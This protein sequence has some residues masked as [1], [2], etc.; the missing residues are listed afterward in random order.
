ML[1]RSSWP[2]NST[3]TGI[4][5]GSATV[6]VSL[7][8]NVFPDPVTGQVVISGVVG[9]TEANATWYYLA[10]DSNQFQL[11]HDVARSIPVDG[12]AWTAYVSGGTAIAVTFKN[13]SITGGNIQITAN[14]STTNSWLFSTNG[15]L[16]L[17]NAGNIVG[18]TANNDGS[19]Q[20]IGNSSGDGYGYTTLQLRPDNTLIG[21]D[22]YLIVDPTS[23]NHIHIRA[24]G[25]QDNSNSYLFLGGETSHFQVPAGLNPSVLVSANSAVW[26]FGNDGILTLP[27]EG[28]LKSV[29]ETVTLLSLNTSTG[30]ANSVYLGTSGG[31]GFM[32]QEIGRAHV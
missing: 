13:L 21:N 10:V 17:P 12:T 19:L 2:F 29:D 7:T 25:T 14:G 24:G 30:N 16:T 3:I 26:T 22:Q 18:A 28:V 27:G 4:T 1:F 11:F 20:W 8:D 31:L 23:P 6:V 15:N 9:T 5:T 32:D